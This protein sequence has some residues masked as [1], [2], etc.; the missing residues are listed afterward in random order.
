MIGDQIGGK[1]MATS[2]G[3]D[4]GEAYLLIRGWEEWRGVRDLN[5]VIGD[6]AGG[7]GPATGFGRDKGGAS[8]HTSFA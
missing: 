8:F 6:R 4:E 2:F 1:G 7:K 3:R 5:H